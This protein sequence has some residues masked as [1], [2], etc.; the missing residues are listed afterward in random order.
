MADYLLHFRADAIVQDAEFIHRELLGGREKWS[1]LGQSFVGFCVTHYL[2]AA[3]DGLKEAII[4]GGLPP[5]DRPVDDIYQA[6]WPLATA[7][8]LNKFTI[9]SKGPLWSAGPARN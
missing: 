7:R 3:P 6:T 1:A 8:G 4:T 2:S 5:L 9:C